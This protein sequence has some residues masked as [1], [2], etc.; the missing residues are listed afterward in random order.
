MAAR[1]PAPKPKTGSRGRGS[2]RDPVVQVRKKVGKGKWASIATFTAPNGAAAVR[3]AILAGERPIDG[4]LTD[5]EIESR[6]TRDR[7]G[8]LSGSELYVKLVK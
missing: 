1:R 2:R 7:H 5:W 4:K 3:R 8:E 6:R